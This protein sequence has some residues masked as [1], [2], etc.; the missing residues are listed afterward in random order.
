MP[1]SPSE[2]NIELQAPGGLRSDLYRGLCSVIHTN[3]DEV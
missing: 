3:E 2:A 1:E